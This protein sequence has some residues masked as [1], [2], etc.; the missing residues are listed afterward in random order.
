MNDLVVILDAGHGGIDPSTGKYVTPGK[1]SPIWDDGTQ[2]FEGVGNRE[3]VK[4]AAKM[5]KEAGIPVFFTVDPDDFRDV[6]F[7]TRI[8]ASNKVF[9]KYKNAIQ[10]SVHSNAAAVEKANGAEVFTSPG[11]TKSD[12]IATIWLAQHKLM[13]PNVAL[14]TDKSDGDVDKEAEFGINKVK[15]PSIL[16]ETFFHTNREECR[17]LQSYEGK[18]KIAQA[19]FN[20]VLRVKAK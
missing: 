9:A 14:R 6:G 7:G 2:Y 12:K 11:E 8:S 20:T 1:R 18:F 17:I 15:C 13:F 5:L 4:I 19:I 16:I 10:I 3:I